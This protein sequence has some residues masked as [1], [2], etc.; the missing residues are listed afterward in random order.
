MHEIFF[1]DEVHKFMHSHRLLA[2]YNS[3]NVV[4]KMDKMKELLN[5]CH[6]TPLVDFDNTTTENYSNPICVDLES[7]GSN[8]THS[9]LN[10]RLFNLEK[11]LK[12]LNA[13]T[14]YI[15][16]G[17][18]GH[19][20]KGTVHSKTG[21][22]LMDFSIKV[23]AYAC[24]GSGNIDDINRPEN[25]ELMMMRV[26]SQFVVKENTIHL[27]VPLLTFDT[28]LKYLL[29]LVNKSELN[30]KNAKRYD[31]FLKECGKGKY[32]NIVS[33]LFSEW[34]D[35]GDLLDFLKKNYK[36]LKLKQWKIIFFQLLSVLAVIQSKYPTFRHNDLKANNVLV[37][38]EVEKKYRCVQMICGKKYKFQNIG[39]ILKL[40]DFDFA[41]IPGK[42]DNYKVMALEKWTRK[43]NVV[44]DQNRYY[45][46]HYFFNTLMLFIPEILTH[47]NVPKEIVEFL[48]RVVPEKFRIQ[49]KKKDGK[50]EPITTELVHKRGRILTNDEFLTPQK[51][52]EEDPFFSELRV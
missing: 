43:I 32:C 21:E 39:I 22:P 8:N 24:N 10:K 44:P 31:E 3:L 33:V 27:F 2:N 45:D 12:V 35:K 14:T 23:S 20:L 50:L 47:K 49:Y 26:L 7:T 41:C 18:T 37:C 17:T 1:I 52:I 4:P 25:A 28:K 51:I 5:V 42:V 19:T 13:T 29:S 9:M 40:W 36:E 6:V 46:V 34:A 48:D 16:S 15:K 30:D 11:V 38:S